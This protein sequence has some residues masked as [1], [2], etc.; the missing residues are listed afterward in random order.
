MFAQCEPDARSAVSS[1]SVTYWHVIP[2]P[3][4]R[5]VVASMPL[6]P[7]RC[8]SLFLD[9][10]C[11]HGERRAQQAW[12]SVENYAAL[13]SSSFP[14]NASSGLTALGT[15]PVSGCPCRGSSL[16]NPCSQQS[17]SSPGCT[18]WKGSCS[19]RPRSS[20]RTPWPP[21]EGKIKERKDKEGEVQRNFATGNASVMLWPDL[22]GSD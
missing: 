10:E 17:R 21:K 2:S 8:R 4:A 15:V 1:P 22:P 14:D 7:H 19:S 5:H 11:A 12:L 16:S 20:S 18:R 3:D 9:H 13:L 6:R